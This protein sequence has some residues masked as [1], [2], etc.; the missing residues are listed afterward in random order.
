[1]VKELLEEVALVEQEAF[2]QSEG[3]W[4]NVTISDIILKRRLVSFWKRRK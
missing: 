3:E 2:C 4:S 1:M